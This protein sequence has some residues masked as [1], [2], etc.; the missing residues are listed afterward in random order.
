MSKGSGFFLLLSWNIWKKIAQSSRG[1]GVLESLPSES[2]D[3]PT[4]D[5]SDEEVPSNNLLE[6]SSDSKKTMEKLNKTQGAAVF[7][8]KIQHFLLQDAIS[9]KLLGSG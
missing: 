9:Q 2:S 1:F 6:F 3:S 8:Q 7:I 5:S 4:G